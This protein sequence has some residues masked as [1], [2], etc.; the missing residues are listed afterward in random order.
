MA[1]TLQVFAR[2]LDMVKVPT[3]HEVV[4]TARRSTKENKVPEG[5]RYR[6]IF[7]PELS[8]AE[9]GIP[10]K[11][12]GLVLDAL[13]TTAT[14]QLAAMWDDSTDGLKE[15]PAEVWGVES[16]LA[17]AERVS[18]SQR[19][20]KET[21]ADWF[22]ASSI[23]GKAKAKGPKIYA[24]YLEGFQGIAG[25]VNFSE[26]KCTQLLALLAKEGDCWQV[27]V[28]RRKLAERIERLQEEAEEIDGFAELDD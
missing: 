20:T 7:I 16:L 18:Q 19:L 13:R 24:K 28:M 23:G 2:P 5:D 1:D 4:S 3:G 25:A 6:A 21:I 14:K 22:G 26:E 9:S 12:A 15:V 27:V 8:V 10:T 11:F 17:F